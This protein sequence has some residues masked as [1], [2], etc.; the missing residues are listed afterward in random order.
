M[1]LAL[2]LSWVTLASGQP[3]QFE[4]DRRGS[5]IVQVPEHLA[6]PSII[7]QPQ[8]QIVPS[9]ALASFFVVA[10]QT[11]NLAYQ[12]RFNGTNINGA[13][14]DTLLLQNVGS[15]NEGQY[16]AVLVNS[17]GSV[18]SAPAAMLLDGDRDGLPDSWELASFGGLDQYPTGDFDGDGVSNRDEFLD[19]TSPTNS[20]SARFRLTVLSNGGLVTVVPSRLSYTNGEVVTLTATALAPQIFRGWTGDTNTTSNPLTLT[21]T[22]NKTVFA[23]LG[24]AE[25]AWTNSAGGNWHVASN[26]EPNFIPTTNDNVLIARNVTITVN[27]SAECGRLTF[28]GPGGTPTLTGTGTLTVHR[29]SSWTSGHMMGSGRTVINPGAT[30]HMANES[31]IN[32]TTRTLENGG[33]FLWSGA[34]SINLGAAAVITNRAGA[35]FETRG[36]GEMAFGGRG[37]QPV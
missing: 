37:E 12:W 7:A 8:P 27:N 20:A 5:L 32:L 6:R 17:S 2:A 9:G 24:S 36:A 13:T 25:I 21:M 30:L 1:I 34:G 35:L 3:T 11:H 23:Y 4:F 10:A 22:A 28:G 31:G 33:T 18:T 15:T 19:G 26:W 14:T 29:D 16:S